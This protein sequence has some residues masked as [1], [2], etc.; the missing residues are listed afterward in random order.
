M[1]NKT[2]MV[3]ARQR[4]CLTKTE[5]A[6]RVGVEPRAISGFEAG[7]YL[8]SEETVDKL[9]KVLNYPREFFFADD[10]DVPR[11]EGVSFRSMTRMTSKQRD[12]AIAAGAI[13]YL[14]SDWLER[15]FDLPEVDLPDLREDGPEVAAAS[16]RQYWGLG[17]RPVRNMI[18]LLEAKGVRVFSLAENSVEVDAYSVWRGNRPCVF[19]NTMKSAERRRFDAAHELGHLVLH[20]HA[21][22]AGLEAEKE[23]NAFA[24]A[25]LMPSASMK[26]LGRITSLEQ[27]IEVKKKWIVSV[28]ALAY[29]LHDLRLLSDWNYHTLCVEMSRRGYRKNE[30]HEAAKESS[31]VWQKVFADERKSGNTLQQLADKLLIPSAELVK[32]VFGLVTVAVHS[33]EGRETVKPSARPN[34]RLV[35]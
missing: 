18:H 30:P 29:R 27:L 6:R 19:L 9:C 23:A 33:S 1:F 17:E 25:F 5:L 26:S 8:P 13:A 3:V 15:E 34:L 32:L 7:E 12:A 10:I 16:L 24:S 4:S 22:P 14:L 31:Q 11:T 2:R 21:A 20:K 35:R 28:A